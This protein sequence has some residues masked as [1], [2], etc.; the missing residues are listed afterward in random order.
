MCGPHT[1]KPRPPPAPDD[2]I[3]PQRQNASCG[4]HPWEDVHE[5]PTLTQPAAPASGEHL[6]PPLV[7]VVDDDADS[8]ALYAGFL[9]SEG[10]RVL[11]AAQG[12]EGVELALHTRPDL[13]ITDMFLPHVD[14]C[15]VAR[16]LHADARTSSTRILGMTSLGPA[17]EER[18]LQAGCDAF[19]SKSE[20]LGG[21]SQIIG[22]LLGRS[23]VQ[24]SNTPS[25]G[26][27]PRRMRL[28]SLDDHVALASLGAVS[29]AECVRTLEELGFVLFRQ[30]PRGAVRLIRH[31]RCVD[32]PLTEEIGPDALVGLL[33]LASV[34]VP[35]FVRCFQAARA[36][37]ASER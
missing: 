29:G 16:R 2:A 25:D 34:N 22:E 6:R 21:L 28:Q 32:V 37:K 20:G 3:P 30:Q 4:E 14:G 17:W 18:M 35:E 27:R 1:V 10:C 33:R 31:A 13:V 8:R 36:A 11:V 15:E 9:A 12:E 24:P 5:V 26:A 23:G 19:L 7:V